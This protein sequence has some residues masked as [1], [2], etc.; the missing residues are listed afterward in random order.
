[1]GRPTIDIIFKQKAITAI[2]RSQLGIV[3]LIVKE[4]TKE[5]K[6]KE[7]KIITDVDDDDYT[8]EFLQL[9]KDCFEFTP[10]K[11]VIFNLK[12][13]TLAGGLKEVAKERI[14][15]KGLS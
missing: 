3:G 11:V 7:Y 1:M 6:R 4:T 5:W 15:W 9:V 10:A 13:G 2:K 8:E 14:N 12:D